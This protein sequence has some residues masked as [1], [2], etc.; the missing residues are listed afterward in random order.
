MLDEMTW[1]NVSK[2]FPFPTHSK[3]KI[4]VVGRK[5][6][7]E[8]KPAWILVFQKYVKFWSLSLVHF[9]KYKHIISKEWLFCWKWINDPNFQVQ[10]LFTC[11]YRRRSPDKEV[12]NI[13]IILGPSSQTSSHLLPSP[14]GSSSRSRK[15]LT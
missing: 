1:W 6:N 14:C 15:E 9:I 7:R 8:K 3:A 4:I 5:E 13:V 2:I 10:V 12:N 11:V